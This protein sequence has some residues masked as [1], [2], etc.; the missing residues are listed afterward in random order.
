MKTWGDPAIGPG[1]SSKTPTSGQDSLPS[2]QEGGGGEWGLSRMCRVPASKE[3]LGPELP[4]APR[5][6]TVGWVASRKI[7]C[8]P[9]DQHFLLELRAAGMTEFA[10]KLGQAVSSKADE[11]DGEM[12]PLPLSWKLQSRGGSGQLWMALFAYMQMNSW[13]PLSQPH[14]GR[15]RCSWQPSRSCAEIS[16]LNGSFWSPHVKIPLNFFQGHGTL[17]NL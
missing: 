15:S 7:P 8:S 13:L 5:E 3:I 6:S 16:L 14:P 11:T 2:A 4:S 17:P 10:G 12:L 1:I 9:Q